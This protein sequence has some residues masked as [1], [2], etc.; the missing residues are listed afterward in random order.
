MITKPLAPNYYDWNANWGVSYL[1]PRRTL[2]LQVR[3][4]L[5]PR[6]I[7][8]AATATDLRPVYESSHQRWDATVRWTFSRAYSLELN[9]ANLT[10][11]SWRNFYQGG[12]N[13]SRRTFGTNYTLA[14]RANLD[15]LRLPLL[16]R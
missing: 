8:T 14:F 9:G 7:T 12:R 2:Y 10:N 5:F 11:D 6:A 13:T 1:T 16:D 4:T 15:Q 3:T